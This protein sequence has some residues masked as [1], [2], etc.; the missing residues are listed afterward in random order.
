MPSLLS[1]KNRRKESTELEL[2]REMLP[3]IFCQLFA[4]S[5][6]PTRTAAVLVCSRLKKQELCNGGVS[7]KPLLPQQ[8]DLQTTYFTCWN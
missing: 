7:Q 5:D 8:F 6:I 1:L 4:I 2:K 3:D